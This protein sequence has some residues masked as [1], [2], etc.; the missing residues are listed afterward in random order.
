MKKF[1]VF[2]TLVLGIMVISQNAYSQKLI[3][4]DDFNDNRNNWTVKN[5]DDFKM[6]ISNGKYVWDCY[7][8]DCGADWFFVPVSINQKKFSIEATFTRTGGPGGTMYCY[9]LIWGDDYMNRF[10]CYHDAGAYSIPGDV[11][12]RITDNT[13]KTGNATNTLMVKR[14]KKNLDL[15]VNGK[16]M[17]SVVYTPTKTTSVGFYLWIDNTVRIEIDKIAVYSK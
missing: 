1:G 16:F 13:V 9:G 3:W 8:G 15:Y 5:T 2:L 6:E 14:N 4:S 11:Y 10:S 12:A 17:K 7:N